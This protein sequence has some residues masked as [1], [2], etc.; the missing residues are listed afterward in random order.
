MRPPVDYPVANRMMAAPPDEPINYAAL[1]DRYAAKQLITDDMIQSACRSMEAAQQLP[2]AARPV[3]V[4]TRP[5]LRPCTD[6]V[7][8]R[9]LKVMRLAH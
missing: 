6:L 1:L 8:D 9:L 5:G 3:P 4:D 7:I 2:Y